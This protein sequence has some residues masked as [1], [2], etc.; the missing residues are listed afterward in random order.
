M[1]RAADVCTALRVLL[2]PVLT[3]LLAVPRG[4]ATFL[5]LAVY[6]VAA[7]SDAADGALARA[8]GTASRGGRVFDHGADAVLLFPAF[9]LLAQQGR[10][11]IVLPLAAMTAFA[12]YLFDGWRRGGR[13]GAIDLVGSRSG[14]FGG[15]LNYGV[16]GAAA[17]AAWIDQPLIDR[18]I[19][20]AAI[21]VAGVNALAAYERLVALVSSAP[22]A[23]AGET[24]AR[25]SHSSP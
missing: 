14:A 10:V 9:C 6:L 1:N 13:L 23:R 8:T 19:H 25:G 5:P 18:V 2:A 24:G 21:A 16:V 17:A 11:P 7:A 3:W 20:H 12:L 22:A 4:R 15:V